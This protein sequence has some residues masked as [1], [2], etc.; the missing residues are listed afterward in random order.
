M[1]HGQARRDEVQLEPRCRAVGPVR[2]ALGQEKVQTEA[3]RP[4]GSGRHPGPADLDAPVGVTRDD[5]ADTG[6]SSSP[7]SVRELESRR[8]GGLKQINGS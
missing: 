5:P 1:G 2:M 8:P 7:P 6:C 4:T 3:D